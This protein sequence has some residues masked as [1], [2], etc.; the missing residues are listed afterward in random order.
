MWN[1]SWSDEFFNAIQTVGL[2]LG[3]IFCLRHE[4]YRFDHIFQEVKIFSTFPLPQMAKEFHSL[5]A[6][7][8]QT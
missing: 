3:F 4:D 5:V 2:K 6:S 1:Y 7:E 8:M